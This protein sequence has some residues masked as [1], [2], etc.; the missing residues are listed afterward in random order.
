[1]VVV[2]YV[3]EGKES[4]E[5]RW[6]TQTLLA[7]EERGR[8]SNLR[9]SMTQL[10]VLPHTAPCPQPPHS[11]P[12]LLP[13]PSPRLGYQSLEQAPAGAFLSQPILSSCLRNGLSP[14]SRRVRITTPFPVFPAQDEGR[15]RGLGKEDAP[16]GN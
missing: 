14:V 3:D 15:E 11:S 13:V 2:V 5:M 6:P 16:P 9:C 12:S 8:N 4:S 7:R 1:M 10:K